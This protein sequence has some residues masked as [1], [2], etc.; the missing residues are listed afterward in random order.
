VELNKEKAG[1]FVPGFFFVAESDEISNLRLVED[2][3]KIQELID[4]EV[5]MEAY[6]YCPL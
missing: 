3:C 5:D 1:Y 2:I 4:T 6:N